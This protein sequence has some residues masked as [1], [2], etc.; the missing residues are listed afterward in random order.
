L[1]G[2]EGEEEVPLRSFPRGAAPE[3]AA[4]PASVPKEGIYEG[5]DATAPGRTY[6]GQSGDIPNRLA[7]HQA[8]GKFAPGTKVST[9]EV[10]GGKTVREIAEHNRIQQ[11]GGVKS[12]PDSQTSN[13]RNSIGR[14]REHLLHKKDETAK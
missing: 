13:I 11:L 3:S 1:V 8:S 4:A 10:A 9:T 12:K 5:P 7:Q 2:P 14:N 6:V